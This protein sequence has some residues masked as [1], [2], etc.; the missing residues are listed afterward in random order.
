MRLSEGCHRDNVVSIYTSADPIAQPAE[1]SRG[2]RSVAFSRP[3]HL[4]D[5]EACDDGSSALCLVKFRSAVLKPAF[6][7]HG[8]PHRNCG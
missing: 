1:I 5:K 7:Q 3:Y 4:R 2:D 8:S 6:D